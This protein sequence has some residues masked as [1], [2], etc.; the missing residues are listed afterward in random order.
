MRQDTDI[1]SSHRAGQGRH[2]CPT[3]TPLLQDRA[4]AEE[5]MDRLL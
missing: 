5:A 1:T 3:H 2:S 4:E